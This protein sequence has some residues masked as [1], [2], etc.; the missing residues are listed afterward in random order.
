M[1]IKVNETKEA[2]ITGRRNDRLFTKGDRVGEQELHA[3]TN[4][5]II[6]PNLG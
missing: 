1:E 2:N 5:N 3:Y 6:N 4:E